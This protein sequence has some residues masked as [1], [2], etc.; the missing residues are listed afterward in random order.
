MIKVYKLKI[1]EKVYEVELEDVSEK[2]GNI[3]GNT[4]PVSAAPA[5]PVAQQATPVSSAEGKAVEAPMQGVILSVSVAVGD[6]VAEGD[7]L[8][9]LEAMKMENPILAPFAGTVV[10]VNVA[11]GDNVNDGTVLVKIS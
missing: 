2:Q 4:A 8:L 7:E 10:E 6:T 11:K 3:A 5:A 1:G 9:I